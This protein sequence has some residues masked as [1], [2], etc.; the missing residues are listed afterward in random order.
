MYKSWD[1]LEK[2]KPKYKNKNCNKKGY[3]Q[4]EWIKQRVFVQEENL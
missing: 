2:K 1:F 4:K 3:R